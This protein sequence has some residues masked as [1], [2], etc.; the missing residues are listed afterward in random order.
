MVGQLRSLMALVALAGGTD[1]R[2]PP[3]PKRPVSDSYQGV[4][5]PDDYRWLENGDDP[6]VKAWSEAQNGAARARLDGLPGRQV[7]RERIAAIANFQSPT[8]SGVLERGGRFFASKRQPPAEQAVLVVLS[9]LDDLATERVLYDPNQ[10]DRKGTTY[11]DWY[12]PSPDGRRVALSISERGSEDGTLAILEVA[13]GKLLPDRIP[14]VQYGTAGG[15]VAWKADGSGLWYTRYPRPGE[16]QGRDQFFYQ[17]IWWHTV[18]APVAQDQ[19]A[20]GRDQ[21]R[22]GEH[23]LQAS[24]DGKWV[25]DRVANGDGGDAAFYLSPARPGGSWKAVAAFSDRIKEASFGLDGA[26][27]LHARRDAP[28]GKIVRLSPE[29]PTLAHAVTVVP[30]RPGVIEDYTAT[31]TRLWV[32]ELEGGPSRLESFPLGGGHPAVVA[33]MPISSVFGLERVGQGD[34]VVFENGSY[35]EPPAYYRQ[36]GPTGTPQRTALVKKSPVSFSDC[37]V[38]PVFAS[39]RDGARVPLTIVRRKG[40][41]LDG[42]NPTLLTGYGGYGISMRPGFLERRRVWLDHGGV[43]AVAAIRGGGEYGEAWH[44]AGKLTRKQNVF[45]DFQACARWLIDHRYTSPQHLGIV[46]GSNGGLLMGA[47]ITQFPKLFR[48]V[49]ASVGI[50][51]MLRFEQQANGEFNTTELGTVKDEGQFRALYR[52][53]PYHRVRPGVAYPSVLFLT[54]AHD[55]RVDPMQSRKMTARLQAVGA[56]VL[57]RTSAESGHG[58]GTSRSQRIEEDVDVYAFLFSELGVPLS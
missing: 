14:R 40:T 10:A 15:S 57:L 20:F 30:E 45:D 37:E 54:G 2:P 50:F 12:V 7:L 56:P 35:L 51:D 41:R 18:G 22:I 36:G 23:R 34:T 43:L 27:Y 48:A 47:M 39:S 24:P 3:T 9:S 17:Q 29:D 11:F 38:V 6:E 33:T 13:T 8:Y 19:Y 53:S 31:A 32:V 52:Y 1:V 4:A 55:P 26:L 49:V 42:K 5:V 58:I 21:P 28:R 25:L 16:R 44:E 46:G